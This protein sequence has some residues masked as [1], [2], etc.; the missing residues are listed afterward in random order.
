MNNL[1]Y[2]I[3][4]KAALGIVIKQ[5]PTSQMSTF[6]MAISKIILHNIT[7]VKTAAL[8]L[9]ETLPISIVEIRPDLITI[10]TSQEIILHLA[11]VV[12]LKLF[13][14]GKSSSMYYGN[15]QPQNGNQTYPNINY[16]AGNSSSFRNNN[17][18][19]W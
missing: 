18:S 11:L 8:A 1:L 3:T 4:N 14:L 2:W 7:T 5:N 12:I 15:N 13:I 19:R 9:V 17:S 6:L 10:K 16:Q